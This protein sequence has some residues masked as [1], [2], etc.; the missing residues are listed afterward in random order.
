MT[1]YGLLASLVTAAALSGCLPGSLQKYQQRS[2]SVDAAIPLPAPK[3]PK[4][5][6]KTAP[7]IVGQ[8]KENTFN[9]SA[10]YHHT[11]RTALEILAENYPIHLVDVKAGVI[12]TA[13][14][15]YYLD[16][17]LYRNRLTLVIAA[18]GK[19]SSKLVVNNT[20]E[21]LDVSRVG[22]AGGQVWFPE[23]KNNKEINRVAQ[24]IARKLS[25]PY[26]PA[27]L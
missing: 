1:R 2:S 27:N 26:L 23:L 20:R 16:N 9:I 8:L 14:D 21:V 11:F 22:E 25:L 18:T 13:Y 17:R 4:V 15:T 7:R 24:N 19:A 12:T 6:S 10:S 5:R 3:A